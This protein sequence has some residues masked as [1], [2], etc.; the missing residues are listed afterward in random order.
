MRGM[1][2]TPHPKALGR[3]VQSPRLTMFPQAT[4]DSPRGDRGTA[5]GRT[6]RPGHPPPQPSTPAAPTPSGSHCQGPRL[7]NDSDTQTPGPGQIQYRGH[8][9]RDTH[10]SGVGA[11]QDGSGG[12]TCGRGFLPSCTSLNRLLQL[13]EMVSCTP[14]RL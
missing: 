12:G 1:F 11:T 8:W 3:G 4:A 10:G 9:I 13:P 7:T 5:R 6:T 14:S 2:W